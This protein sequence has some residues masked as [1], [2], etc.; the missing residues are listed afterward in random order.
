MKTITEEEALDHVYGLNLVA[1]QFESEHRWYNRK[2]VVFTQDGD[3]WGFYYD[4]PA[5]E[6]QEGMDVFEA[7][8][9]PVYPVMGVKETRIVYEALTN[10]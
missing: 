6:V 3:L 7:I 8:P 9:V 4:E 2:L 1:I 10:E 5:T